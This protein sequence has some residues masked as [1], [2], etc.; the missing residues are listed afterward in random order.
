MSKYFF[1]PELEAM[2]IFNKSLKLLWNERFQELFENLQF[3]PNLVSDAVFLLYYGVFSSTL[4]V[5]KR[6]S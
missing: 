2:S 4:N 5:W 6:T 1:L 3:W